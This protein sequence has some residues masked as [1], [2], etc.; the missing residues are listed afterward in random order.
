MITVLAFL[1]ALALLI[2][3]HEYGHYRVAKACGV[4]V[5]RFSLGFGPVIARWRRSAADTEFTLSAIPL[6]GYVRML[7]ER[8]PASGPV[9]PQERERAFNNRPLRQRV[10]VVAA[11]PLANLLLAMVL[12]AVTAWIGS[13]EPRALLGSPAAGTLAE[14]AGLRAGDLVR[15]SSHDGA[16]WEEVRSLAQAQSRLVE[17]AMEAAPLILEVSDADGHGARQVRLDTGSF[18]GA[19]YNDAMARQLLLA[20]YAEPVITQVMPGGAGAQAGLQAGD[21]VLAIDGVAQ[22]DAAAARDRVR[23]AVAGGQGRVM[24]WRIERA[25]SALELSVQP[26]VF[27]ADGT[28]IGRIEVLIGSPPQLVEVRYGFV[29]GLQFGIRRTWEMS[30]LTLRMIKRMLVGEASVKNLSGPLSMADYAGQAARA[31]LVVYLSYL[32]MISVSLGVLN[33]LPLPMLDGGHLMYYLFEG[34]SGRPV[35]EWWQQQLQRV[36]VLVLLLVMGLAL[37]N[38]VARMVQH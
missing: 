24:H 29:D 3:V 30:A 36:G 16:D 22:A 19:E 23:A 10:A 5:L 33:L 21:R 38:D 15:A 17:A 32:A 27:D 18:A 20:G 6:G 14:R 2:A 1:V 25:G 13:E 26:R 28:A 12:L 31:G 4:K 7:D 8:D 34:L 9:L 11:G 37:S 35:S